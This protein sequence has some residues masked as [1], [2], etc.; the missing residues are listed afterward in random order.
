MR[1]EYPRKQ[2]CEIREMRLEYLR[3]QNC[4]KTELWDKRNED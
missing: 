3:K 4:K 1:V 2:I